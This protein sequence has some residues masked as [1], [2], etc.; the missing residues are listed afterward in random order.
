[1]HGYLLETNGGI[2]YYQDNIVIYHQNNIVLM[3]ILYD[4]VPK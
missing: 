3:I 2:N 1:M 4:L